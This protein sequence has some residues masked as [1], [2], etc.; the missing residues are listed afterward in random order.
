MV[1]GFGLRRPKT[2]TPR[3]ERGEGEEVCSAPF[4]HRRG[5]LP[6]KADW[7]VPACIEYALLPPHSGLLGSGSPPL[8]GQVRPAEP[9]GAQITA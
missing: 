2:P 8:D 3:A 5:H 6:G 4:D 7:R 1:I 9:P